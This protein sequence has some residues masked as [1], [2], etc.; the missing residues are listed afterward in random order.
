MGPPRPKDDGR[1]F[2]T[3][4]RFFL[5]FLRTPLLTIRGDV[6]RRRP[7]SQPEIRNS[8]RRLFEVEHV[9]PMAITASLAAKAS[10]GSAAAYRAGACWPSISERR[11][12]ALE[13]YY[14]EPEAERLERI[15]CPCC[16]ND[17]ASPYLS[18]RDRLF[19]RPGTYRVVRCRPCGMFYTNPR[20]TLAALG[21]HYPSDYF[22]YEVPENLKGIRRFILGGA[23]RRLADRRLRMIEQ[24][25]G[26]VAS[27]SRVC[28]VGCSY[29]ELLDALKKRR[30]CSVVGVDFNPTMVD[31]CE[32]RGVPAVSGTLVDAAFEEQSFDLVTMT[33]YLEHERNPGE[34]LEECFRITKPSG[35]L[36]IEVPRISASGA[37]LFG[38]YWSQLDLPRHLM[39]FTETTLDRMLR[40]AGYE[41][42]SVRPA[43]GSIGMSLL[44][45]FG[46]ERIGRM[47]SRDLVAAVLATIPLLPFVPFLPEF[48]FVVARAVSRPRLP[49]R[50]CLP[51]AS[52]AVPLRKGHRRARAA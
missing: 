28:D 29:G 43:L 19:G 32:R 38:K 16:G 51:R 2:E 41:I 36:A 8:Y 42:V 25:T 18:S 45:L 21:R 1:G 5:T 48:M 11:A 22:C 39:F 34:V 17:D 20:P 6:S 33:E 13:E 46:Y 12:L 7:Y 14:S 15:A 35:Y 23:I 49:S 44:H 47:T 27:I 10:E 52:V 50:L 9:Q 40:E 31:H 26:K 30:E 37:R 3:T 4:S 24:V